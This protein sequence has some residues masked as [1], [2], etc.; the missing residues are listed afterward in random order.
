MQIAADSPPP[1]RQD[2]ATPAD[3]YAVVDVETTGLDPRLHRVIEC[4]VVECRADGSIC[5]EWSSL[6]QVPGDGVLGAHWIHGITRPMLAGAPAFA[7][8][9]GELVDRLAGR[10][11]VAHVLD[12]DLGHLAAE[13]ARAGLAL[14]ALRPAGAC[15]RELARALLPHGP[16]SLA[17]CCSATGVPL[18]GAHTALGDARAAAGLLAHFLRLGGADLLAGARAAAPGVNWP[19]VEREGSTTARPR[20]FP[21]GGPAIAFGERWR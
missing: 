8:I 4:A 3:R 14:P 16:F 10:V 18:E 12:F 17:A 11:V 7:E 19:P 21:P 5:A 15:T 13:F 6:V 1:L 2:A 20:P 9:T